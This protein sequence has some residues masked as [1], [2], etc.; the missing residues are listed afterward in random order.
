MGIRKG[1]SGIKACEGFLR[2]TTTISFV[3]VFSLV[4]IGCGRRAD[5][6]KPAGG[7]GADRISN[8]AVNGNQTSTNSEARKPDAA[9]TAARGPRNKRDNW[10]NHKMVDADPSATPL[11]LQFQPAAENSAAAVT[12]DDNGMIFE[13]R[14]FK[15]HPRLAR[16]EATWVG[17]KEKDL[18]IFLRN[19]QELNVKTDRL[20]NL[21][22]ATIKDLLDI[23]GLQKAGSTTDHPHKSGL[24]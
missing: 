7:G 24:K 9:N 21:Q 22:T 15:S 8:V 20:K 5:T 12:M 3:C 10:T 14:V 13:V 4:M 16:I 23:A 19:G 17:E 1:G 11:P 18:K 6:A 2:V